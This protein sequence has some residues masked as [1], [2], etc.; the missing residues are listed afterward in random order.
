M[1]FNAFMCFA[2]IIHSRTS[3]FTEPLCYTCLCKLGFSHLLLFFFMHSL[4]GTSLLQHASLV[5]QQIRRPWIWEQLAHIILFK[6][7]GRMKECELG[8]GRKAN[9]FFLEHK[10]ILMYMGMCSPQCLQQS[11]VRFLQAFLKLCLI[12]SCLW[13]IYLKMYSLC[14]TLKRGMICCVIMDFS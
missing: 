5:L 11:I 3:G 1:E 13:I 6:F 12:Y 8:S 2:F 7:W 14:F 4:M 10:Y 9:C